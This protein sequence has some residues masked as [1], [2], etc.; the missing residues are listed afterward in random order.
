MGSCRTWR[1]KFA[2]L[3]ADNARTGTRSLRSNYSS[4]CEFGI[5]KVYKSPIVLVSLLILVCPRPRVAQN[6]E[7]AAKGC[8]IFGTTDRAAGTPRDKAAGRVGDHGWSGS[9]GGTNA[10]T[11]GGGTRDSK[12]RAPETAQGLDPTAKD[13]GETLRRTLL[14]QVSCSGGRARRV[15]LAAGSTPD[16]PGTNRNLQIRMATIVRAM[17]PQRRRATA[18]VFRVW[19]GLP[20]RRDRWMPGGNG[21][22]LF[23]PIA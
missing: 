6:P 19:H 22:I 7:R 4:S 20:R 8:V 5:H 23:A 1:G 10:A 3:D 2:E 13:K 12:Q 16:S 15:V 14:G 9:L 21:E 18:D 11:E 17:L